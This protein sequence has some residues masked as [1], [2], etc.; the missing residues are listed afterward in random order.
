MN[1]GC[2]PIRDFRCGLAAS[3]TLIL[4]STSALAKPVTGQ[5]MSY[6]AIIGALIAG[7][8]LLAACCA[9]LLIYARKRAANAEFSAH[10]DVH[11]LAQRLALSEMLGRFDE[12][13]V[14]FWE[15]P[16]NAPVDLTAD[17][18]SR[19]KTAPADIEQLL[20]FSEWLEATSAAE[21]SHRIEAFILRG[22]T[23]TQ[24]VQTAAGAA[25][26]VETRNTPSGPMLRMR[27]LVEQRAQ[28]VQ[29]ADQLTKTVRELDMLRQLLNEIPI[30][31]WLRGSTGRLSWVNKAYAQ[32]VD[33]V[34]PQQA[35][36]EG[37]ELLDQN[38]RSSAL[39]VLGMT[40]SWQS[41]LLT[42][43]NG[44]RRNL[45]IMVRASGVIEAGCAIDAVN[46]DFTSREVE[47]VMAAHQR[48][49][50]HLG[51]AVAIFG[52]DRKLVYYNHAFQK[53]WQLDNIFL[54]DRPDEGALLD[55]L[56]EQRKL[57]EQADYKAWKAQHLENY[58]AIEPREVWWYLPDGRTLRVFTHPNP[59]GGITLVQE[60][61]TEVLDL[62]SRAAAYERM[63]RE[64]LDALSD[65]VAVFGS[66]GRLRL[67]NP[68]LLEMWEFDPTFIA[69]NPHIDAVITKGMNLYANPV[70]W[71][72]LKQSV[73][74]FGEERKILARQ[75]E[76]TKG[77][78]ADVAC[79]PLPDGATLLTFVD[80]TAAVKVERV[81]KERNE[82]LEAATQL[83]N[84]FI[85]HMSYELRSPLTNIIGFTQLLT[86]PKV[87]P[88]NV[89][90]HEYMDYI[91]SS[92][93]ALLALI[94]DILDLAT[95][96]AGVMELDITSVDVR[97]VMENAAEAL[98]DRCS[99]KSIVLNISVPGQ[100]GSFTADA[101]RVRQALYNVLSNAI[102]FSE[103]GSRI[104][105]AAE[106][107]KDHE[108]LFTVQDYGQGIAE[109]DLPHIFERFESRSKG[110]SH[111]GVGLGLSIVKSVIELHGGRIDMRSTPGKGTLVTLVF[112][113]RLGKARSQSAA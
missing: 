66:D 85:Q 14:L 44:K 35:I 53:L 88:L 20:K 112:P 40:G 15:K 73:I 89:R 38:A 98:R 8:A 10:R 34:S 24:S 54:D 86:D 96:D 100:I 2:E 7:M 49:L 69:Q 46:S 104:D 108:I 47:R 65:A 31:I 77:T 74:A 6:H 42:V 71:A 45:Q 83:K 90:Q 48:T 63:Q 101:R 52:P 76:L 36:S 23:F 70:V 67:T 106:R 18:P 81:L 92:S 56:R 99:E 26:E 3:V 57:P 1:I 27:P 75:I 29:L 97:E 37:Y 5:D 51:T 39:E 43:S 103:P 94:N 64:T 80:V 41:Q 102:G 21:L 32:A 84:D 61:V 95:I 87:G 113:C 78:V 59:Q 79:L 60:N 58:S 105:F 93:A 68:A 16:H 28:N 55:R 22:E 19:L 30:P 82:A 11:L 13:V 107:N 50:D 72:E 109:D 110:S 12:Q 9:I 17:T 33:A 91:T 62:K 25:L 111:R 4:T